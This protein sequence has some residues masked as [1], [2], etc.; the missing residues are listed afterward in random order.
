V[1][2]KTIICEGRSYEGAVCGGAPKAQRIDCCY[3][4]TQTWR[5]QPHPLRNAVTDPLPEM[6]PSNPGGEGLI[7]LSPM[8]ATPRLRPVSRRSRISARRLMLVIDYQFN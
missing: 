3:G 7:R 1:G 6:W 8:L 5:P 2:P 4:G